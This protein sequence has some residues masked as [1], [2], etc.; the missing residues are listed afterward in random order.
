MHCCSPAVRGQGTLFHCMRCSQHAAAIPKSAGLPKS[1]REKPA[2]DVESWF[3]LTARK[4]LLS[5]SCTCI[6]S[7]PFI[8]AYWGLETCS[9]SRC[10]A[11]SQEGRTR[12]PV[13]GTEP[14]PATSDPRTMDDGYQL[15]QIRSGVGCPPAPA[16]V[17][18][19]PALWPCCPA[20]SSLDPQEKSPRG[21]GLCGKPG[22][23]VPGTRHQRFP[24]GYFYFP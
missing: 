15:P 22:G 12:R 24:K 6:T 2:V 19:V 8:S 21:A 10:I 4:W 18:S 11:T 20:F 5:A 7:L 14:S 16:A 17:G 3:V 1:V 9:R 23:A 13:L